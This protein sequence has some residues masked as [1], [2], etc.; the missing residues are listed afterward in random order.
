MSSPAVRLAASNQPHGAMRLLEIFDSPASLRD[1]GRMVL[2]SLFPAPS[3][4]R[5]LS[6]LARRGPVGLALAY[7]GRWL[8][9]ARGLPA[10]IRA[11]RWARRP[12]A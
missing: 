11:V 6:P 1:R 2:Q 8:T 3:R 4:L 12:P 5:A 10:A 7:P 9:H